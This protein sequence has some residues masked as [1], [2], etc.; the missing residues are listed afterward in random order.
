M[1]RKLSLAAFFFVACF[2][3]PAFAGDSAFGVVKDVRAANV[4]TLA[5]GKSAY[6]VRLVA[7][8]PPKEGKFAEEAKAFVTQAALGRHAR[9][10]LSHTE[11]EEFVAIL[12][13]EGGPEGAYRDLGLELVRRGLARA[14]PNRFYK[15]GDLEAAQKEAQSRRVGMW[16]QP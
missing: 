6:V 14:L 9:F 7:V 10:L 11:G 2:A 16:G 8:E 5:V 12:M 4:V 3:V 1:Q 13:V 15:Y